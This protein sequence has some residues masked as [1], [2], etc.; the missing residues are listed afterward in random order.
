M[1]VWTRNYYNLLTAA[2][3]CDDTGSS[4]AT[5]SDYTPPIRV[6]RYNGAYASA[7][8]NNGLQGVSIE[9]ALPYILPPF[10]KG[11]AYS[12]ARL[13]TS[14][15]PELSITYAF[16]IAVGNGSTPATYEDYNMGS[17]ITSG[18]T[19]ANGWGS[20]AQASTYNSENHHITSKRSYT[21]TNSSSSSIPVSEVGIFVHY[22][23]NNYSATTMIYHD[24][25]DTI[26]LEPG[27]SLILTFERDAE[28]F[29]YTPY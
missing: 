3:L 20:L 29:N 2:L 13:I 10:T 1:G 15:N 16:G 14:A 26:I 25:F 9:Y 22:A 8:A 27:E 17:Y 28:V 12:Q 24:V 19:L 11:G 5:P 23:Q 6:R 21:I 18:L 4:S 7:G